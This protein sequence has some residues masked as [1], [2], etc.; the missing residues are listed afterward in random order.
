MENRIYQT[1]QMV[2]ASLSL[3]LDVCSKEVVIEVKAGV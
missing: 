2:K 3:G 1:P